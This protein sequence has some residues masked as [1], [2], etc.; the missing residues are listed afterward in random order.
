MLRESI[1]ISLTLSYPKDQVLKIVIF[2]TLQPL[3]VFVSPNPPLPWASKLSNV[4]EYLIPHHYAWRSILHWSIQLFFHPLNYPALT[5]HWLLKLIR[6]WSGALLRLSLWISLYWI[7]WRVKKEEE[8]GP[9]FQV[10]SVSCLNF[11][12]S[13]VEST[14]FECQLCPLPIMYLGANYL[15]GPWFPQLYWWLLTLWLFWELNSYK[16]LRL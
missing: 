15:F 3:F 5:E 6:L 13:R 7:V 11:P 8:H 9:G 14:Q 10:N 16:V 4:F 1:I 12:A 2:I